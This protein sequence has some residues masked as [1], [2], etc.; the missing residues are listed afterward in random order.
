M[1]ST[2]PFISSF[3]ITDLIL[4]W[5]YEVRRLQ[6]VLQS[7]SCSIFFSVLLQNLIVFL[8]FAFCFTMWSA[9][10]AH[11]LLLL[12]LLLWVFYWSLSNSKSPQVSKT[13]L[14]I[15]ANLNNTV[16]WMV[17]I[18]H[19]ISNS[20]SPL[21]K[22]FGTIL[23]APTTVGITVTRE[24]HIFN[25]SLARFRYLYIFLSS[26][27]FTQWSSRTAKSTWRQMPFFMLSSNWS[28]FLAWIGDLFVSYKMLA[29]SA[30][31]EE[32]AD[33]LSADG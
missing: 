15:L 13:Y 17:L 9:W 4:W 7:P 22:S 3:Q 30:E 1:V 8:L 5:L 18:L 2:F 16:L 12:L 25:S 23:R 21:F 33:C 28:G 19:L 10:A 6:L 14:M 32:Y 29:Q 31:T 27:I 26:F 11:P 20:S 24:F